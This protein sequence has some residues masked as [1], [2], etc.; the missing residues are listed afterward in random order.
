MK[1]VS[2]FLLLLC[3]HAS[4]QSMHIVTKTKKPLD[5]KR[6]CNVIPHNVTEKKIK[7]KYPIV[8]GNI[9]LGIFNA[10]LTR[11][12]LIK[13]GG[14]LPFIMNTLPPLVPQALVLSCF[15]YTKYLE[16]QE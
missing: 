10:F 3:T 9:Q 1:I 2:V 12:A 5:L 11:T 4:L 6:C 15:A 7:F 14:A 8:F 16:K 13:S